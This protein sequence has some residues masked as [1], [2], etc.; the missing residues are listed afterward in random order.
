MNYILVNTSNLASGR[1]QVVLSAEA[2]VLI[3]AAYVEID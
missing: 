2:G 3:S 1:Y